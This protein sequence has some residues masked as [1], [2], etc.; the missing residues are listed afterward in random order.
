MWR[1]GVADRTRGGTPRADSQR[2][3]YRTLLGVVV[4][5]VVAAVIVQRDYAKRRSSRK[6]TERDIER[7]EGEGMV[8]HAAPTP[9]T[10]P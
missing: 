8:I 5:A 1:S 4:L 7:A 9:P 3:F 10:T 2:M 6:E